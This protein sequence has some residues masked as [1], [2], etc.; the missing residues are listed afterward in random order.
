MEIPA[1]NLKVSVF[2]CVRLCSKV[3]PIITRLLMFTLVIG[4]LSAT[5]RLLQLDQFYFNFLN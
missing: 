2:V 3:F 5:A 4:L 1:I